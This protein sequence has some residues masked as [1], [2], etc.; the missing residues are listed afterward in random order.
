[1]NLKNN[2]PPGYKDSPLGIIP[3]K[4]EVMPLGNLSTS[5]SSGRNK[6][7]EQ[8]DIYPV[9]GSTGIIGYSSTYAYNGVTILVA[10]V[11]ANA[12]TLNLVSGQYDV[13][14][15]TLIII[16]KQNLYDYNF[17]YNQ[18]THYNL[19]KLVFG[20][21]Q[22]LITSKQ[23]KNIKIAVPPIEEQR[24][25]AEI[26]GT[27]D[28]AIGK[29]AQ[30]VEKL[31]QRKRGLMQ[32][33]LSGRQRLPGFSEKWLPVKLGNIAVLKKGKQINKL[34]LHTEGKYPTLNGG[35]EPSGYFDNYNTEEDTITI[36][37]GG[38][39][40]GYVNYI[41]RKFWCGGHCYAVH[42]HD[43]I[44]KNF[45]F[46]LLKYKERNIMSLRIG[47]GLPNI[48]IKPLYKFNLSLPSLPEQKAIAEVL[49]AA[50]YQ[51]DLAK[52]KLARLRRQK[53]G[54]MQQLLTGKKQ[55]KL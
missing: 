26:L 50:D 2:I 18:L 24:Q 42:P 21:G 52:E 33:L 3:Q 49:T 44:N 41:T 1:M 9:Y 53:R 27:W 15:N 19:N 6:H 40:C 38:N 29:Q 55:L 48:Q 13:S 12:G 8:N 39:S 4:W 46:Q 11:G 14:D 47:S 51:I 23:L 32:R 30:L 31:E 37:E 54:L 25:I 10:R 45:L 20:S 28:D 17:A 36:S 22:P 34:Q 16:I 7:R 5:I 43:D 35:I